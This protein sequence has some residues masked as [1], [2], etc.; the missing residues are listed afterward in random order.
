[1]DNQ[2]VFC[3]IVDKKMQTNFVKTLDLMIIDREEI[4]VEYKEVLEISLPEND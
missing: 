2:V 3:L 1:M 4:S